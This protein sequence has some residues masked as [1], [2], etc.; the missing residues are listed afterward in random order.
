MNPLEMLKQKLMVKP[1]VEERE[2]VAVVIKGEKKPKKLKQPKQVIDIIETQEADN[3]DNEEKEAD[4]AEIN[5]PKAVST[6]DSKQNL[7]IIV[8]ET[9]K[10]FDRL[11][12]LKKLKDAKI[13][14]V[15]MKEVSEKS[16]EKIIA[17]PV[18]PAPVKKAKKISVKQT[19]L[20]ESDEEEP[21]KPQQEQNESPEEYTFTK[22]KSKAQP[23][24][25]K[26]EEQPEEVIPVQVKEKKR[27][28][29]K[30]PE[31]GVAVLGP[32]T[33][34]KIGDTELLKRI[35]SKAPPI[36]IK[37]SKYYMN[38][39]EIFI[40]FINSLFEPYKIELNNN[41]ESISCDTIGKTTTDFSLLTH[42]KIVRDYMNIYTPYRGLLLYHGLGSGKTCTSIGIAEG[43][44]DAKCVIIMTPASLQANYKEELKKCGDLLYKRNQYWEWIDTKKH[45]EA[46]DP[47]SAIL[48]LDVAYIQKHGG[49][50]FV[51]INKKSNYDTLNDKQKLILEEQINE[52]IHKKYKFINYNG[53]RSQRLNELTSGYT[54]NIF[55]NSVVV[56]DE[57]HNFIS[58]IVNKLKKETKKDKEKDNE[59]SRKKEDKENDNIFGEE[60]PINLATKLY[61]MLLRAQ[62]TKI[63]LLTGTPVIN[64]PNEFAI[65][66][67]ILRG[68]I[69]TWKIPLNIKTNKKIDRNSLQEILIGVK[70]L[71]YLDYNPTQKVLTIT[72][73]PFA[74]RNKISREAGYQGVQTEYIDNP[75]YKPNIVKTKEEKK[76]QDC[77]KEQLKVVNDSEFIFSDDDFERRIISV[78]RRNDIDVVPEGI[79]VKNMKA[80]PDNLDLFEGNYIDFDTKKLKNIDSLRRR[81]IGLTSY[82]RSAQENLL[83]TFKKQP[84]YDYHVIKIPMSDFQFKIYESAR[85]EERKSEKPKRKQNMENLLNESTSTYRIFSR[86]FCNYVVPERPVPKSIRMEATVEKIGVMIH[87][88]SVYEKLKEQIEPQLVSVLS[89]I[90]DEKERKEWTDKIDTNLRSYMTDVINSNKKGKTAS[91]KKLLNVIKDIEKVEEI[92]LKVKKNKK[93]NEEEIENITKKLE[94]F[95]LEQALIETGYNPEEK[96]LTQEEK[97]AMT[98]L[99]KEARKEETR[100]DVTDEREGEIEGDE[101][102]DE[103]GGIDYKERLDKAIQHIVNNSNDFLTKE[104]LQTYSPKFLNILENITDKDYDGLHL[105]YS[106]F[107]TAEGIGLFCKVLDKNGFTRFKIKKNSTGVW[108]ID[109]SEVDEGKPTYALYTGTETTEEKEIVRHIYNGEWD[110]IPESISKVLKNKYR[111]NN[112][113][114]VVKVLMITSS[115]SEG[116]NLKNTRYV[117]IMEPYWHPVRTE[118]VIGR[119]RRICSHKDLPKELQTVEV[120]IYLMTFTPEQ[121]KSEEAIELKRKDLSKATPKVPQTSDEYLYEISEIKAN[122]TKQLTD[123][124]KETSFDC[125]IY[126]N[127]KCVNFPNPTNNKFSYVPD[128]SDQKNDSLVQADS[129]EEKWVG[130]LVT[131]K[132][133]EYVY[134]EM[135][136]GVIKLYDKS[137]YLD[138]LK[139]PSINIVQIGTLDIKENGDMKIIPLVA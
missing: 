126:S 22:K 65:L 12:L 108:E 14:K 120:F 54:K 51:N 121:L 110:Q 64:Y 1:T 50:W 136:D 72:K 103:I 34:S 73:N 75:E 17:P 25:E 118:Q 49:A 5:A 134:R 6:R 66:F 58:R 82:F 74:F 76:K 4:N 30:K 32:E 36:I 125:F 48:N 95:D 119:A 69:K 106:Q 116:I 55:D 40:N 47:I 123:I 67:N 100:Q 46:L 29:T 10:G 133:V 31:K 28:I 128:F 135:S 60:V 86:L 137:S 122:L 104:A 79:K 24:E 33:I 84:G 21:N 130:K 109:I 19:Q 85:R 42:Q 27:R 138:A 113:G 23:E 61:Y 11:A 59:E 98:D 26:P 139:D 132:G 92:I 35:P 16:Q 68:Y 2:R 71:D 127:G 15:T 124:V 41:K 78:L 18:E 52:M 111:N 9:S 45:P 7:P 114:E 37:T 80:L 102:L 57:A 115:G 131:I 94:A 13:N 91:N 62:N 107:R 89:Q 112:M 39:R 87:F 53:L 101:I 129:Y 83:P 105:V 56:I 8:D 117:H 90:D 20:I 88:E 3:E 99:L 97:S 38:N 96:E 93:N 81:I 77:N 43:M 63:I 70:S 44:K